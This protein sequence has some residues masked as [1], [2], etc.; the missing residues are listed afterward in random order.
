MGQH[1]PSS[2]PIPPPRGIARWLTINNTTHS[3]HHHRRRRHQWLNSPCCLLTEVI[4]GST[5]QNHP[6]TWPHQMVA[7]RQRT[8][9]N[10]KSTNQRKSISRGKPQFN[11]Y[12]H[13]YPDFNPW[14]TRERKNIQHLR[15][16]HSTTSSSWLMSWV[17]VIEFFIPAPAPPFHGV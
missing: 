6:H 4:A 11:Y 7:C 1:I 13:N 10:K 3:Q 17:T 15:T 9:V 14:C 8:S 5:P 16:F 12:S 2:I